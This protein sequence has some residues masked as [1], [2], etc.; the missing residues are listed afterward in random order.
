VGKSIRRKLSP[1]F[2]AKV[3]VEAL[4]ELK[5][6]PEIASSNSVHASQVQKW[7]KELKEKI[8]EIFSEGSSRKDTAKDELIDE[9]YKQIG[10]LQVENEWLKK[11]T[12]YFG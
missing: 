10:K 4:K 7:K 1:S 3:A 11:N 2:K 8:H 6:I 12:D 9:L 5:T